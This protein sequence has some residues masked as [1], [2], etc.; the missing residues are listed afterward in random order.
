MKHT[1]SEY[2]DPKEVANHLR[3]SV[4]TL[5]RWRNLGTAPAEISINGKPRWE[6][7]TIRQWVL[8]QNPQLKKTSSRTQL[9]HSINAAIGA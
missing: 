1:E 3:I 6:M 8:D 9:D 2:L 5:N 7:A 4:P